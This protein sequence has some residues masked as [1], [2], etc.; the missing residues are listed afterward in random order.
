MRCQS[1]RFVAAPDDSARYFP[2]G[3]DHKVWKPCRRKL[4]AEESREARAPDASDAR[5][6]CRECQ[7]ALITCPNPTIRRALANEPGQLL[8]VLESLVSDND[9]TVAAAADRRMSDEKGIWKNN[10]IQNLSR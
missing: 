3:K 4:N 8:Y 5:K 7:D 9:A 6:R 10:A 2:V 1:W